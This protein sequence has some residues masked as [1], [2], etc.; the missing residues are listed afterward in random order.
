MPGDVFNLSQ[1]GVNLTALA[2]GWSS[3]HRHPHESEDGFAYV[4]EG[5]LILV[6]DEGEHVMTPG[7]CVGFKAAGPRK[8]SP[9]Q[10]RPSS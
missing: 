9:C 4:L 5:W 2:L 6:D 10:V 3:G 1:F 8:G 7:M